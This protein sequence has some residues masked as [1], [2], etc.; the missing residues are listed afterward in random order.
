M[1]P[2]IKHAKKS[3]GKEFARKISINSKNSAEGILKWPSVYYTFVL[4]NVCGNDL[5]WNFGRLLEENG[6][7][8][9]G[10]EDDTWKRLV[11]K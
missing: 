11:E 3:R 10:K 7:N 4:F 1:I 8:C 9:R 5:D 2:G 6:I